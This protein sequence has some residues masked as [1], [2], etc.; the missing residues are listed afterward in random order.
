VLAAIAEII[1]MLRLQFSGL[2][3]RVT[4]DLQFRRNIETL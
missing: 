2:A 3:A 4:R 1:G